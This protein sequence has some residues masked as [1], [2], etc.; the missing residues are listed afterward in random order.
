MHCRIFLKIIHKGRLA[1]DC[2]S[3]VLV[4]CY[5]FLCVWSSVHTV[6]HIIQGLK[7]LIP[8]SCGLHASKDR[9]INSTTR[10]IVLHF[11]IN[12]LAH[13]VSI[14]S[15]GLYTLG[16]RESEIVRCTLSN[17][18]RF[19]C[20]QFVALNLTELRG[21]FPCEFYQ[22]SICCCLI[23][24]TNWQCITFWIMWVWCV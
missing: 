24:S 16:V 22:S 18:P 21:F 6:K 12:I 23:T 9:E 1:D 7:Q 11:L 10:L 19:L 20:V 13:C 2:Y 4:D 15:I 14:W 8:G 5:V 17:L 3:T